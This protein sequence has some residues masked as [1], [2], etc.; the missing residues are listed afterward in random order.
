MNNEKTVW[1]CKE[2][3]KNCQVK[4]IQDNLARSFKYNDTLAHNHSPN[5]PPPRVIAEKTKTTEPIE[6]RKRGRPRKVTSVH[7]NLAR[8]FNYNDTSAHNHTTNKA[9]Q[10]VVALK[11]EPIERRK[12]GRPKKVRQVQDNSET[13][14]KYNKSWLLH[15]AS[16]KPP[17]FI[18]EKNEPTERRKR[19][20]PKKVAP[21]ATFSEMV[22]DLDTLMKAY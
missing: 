10:E 3:T 15:N 7:D 9:P 22:D 21:A 20:R 8:S 6:R 4:V 12:R 13:S 19:G 18:E 16:S 11:N 14:F 17:T 2:H 1:G 5:K